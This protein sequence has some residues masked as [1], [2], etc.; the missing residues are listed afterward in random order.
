MVIKPYTSSLTLARG[1]CHVLLQEGA[2]VENF[3]FIFFIV[4]IHERKI[5]HFKAIHR[6]ASYEGK[7][8][9]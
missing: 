6:Y 7:T 5:Q 1:S 4:I 2:H 8:D 9:K 3:Y